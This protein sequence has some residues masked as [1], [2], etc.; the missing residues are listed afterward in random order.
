[1]MIGQRQGAKNKYAI[2]SDEEHK[3]PGERASRVIV[4]SFMR[5]MSS[6]VRMP[7]GY[8]PAR[9][10]GVRPREWKASRRG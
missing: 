6:A 8:R 2:M 5:S 3:G 1:M 7:C 9:Q 10:P 4:C